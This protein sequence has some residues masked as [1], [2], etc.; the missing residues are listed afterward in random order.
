M[1]ITI[2]NGELEQKVGIALKG[3]NGRNSTKPIL[4]CIII[5]AKEDEILLEATN[6]EIGLRVKVD[7]TVE[8]EGCCAIDGKSLADISRKMPEGDV[9][10]QSDE[11]TA[12]I[13]GKKVK[14][15]LPVSDV[16]SF[17]G[18]PDL[19]EM[20]VSCS[21]LQGALKDALNGVLFSIAVTEVNQM[22]SVVHVKCEEGQMR[23]IGLD[24]HRIAIRA[25]EVQ[26]E[27]MELNLPGIPLKEI[28]KLLNSEE[29]KVD[30]CVTEHLA[31]FLMPDVWASMR[32]VEEKYFDISAFLQDKTNRNI[33]IDKTKLKDSVSRAL[34]LLADKV[35]KPKKPWELF[36]LTKDAFHRLRQI[37]GGKE[38][39]LWFQ[40]MEQ[41]HL[42]LPNAV[43]CGMAKE[44]I[45]PANI[46]GVPLSPTVIYNYL[47]RQ[48]TG[49]KGRRHMR[50]LLGTWEDYLSMAAYLKMPMDQDMVLRPRDLLLAH[51]EVLSQCG[52]REKGLRVVEI[53]N[54]FP[55]VEAV[56]ASIKEKYEYVGKTFSIVV[57]E[58]IEQIIEEGQALK[59]CLDRSDRY[60]ERIAN[61]ESY[62]V[63]LRR[64]Q[65]MEQPYYTMEIEPDG[66]T[67]Q[68]RTV[69]DNQNNDYH[70]AEKFLK[71]WQAAIRPRLS[72]EDFERQEISRQLRMY[73]LESLRN[74]KV[75]VHGGIHAGELLADILEA[76]LMEA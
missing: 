39:I 27:E 40:Y 62:I 58:K 17:P 70:R 52:G 47:K 57:P 34:L 11:K 5:K 1:K 18:L 32:L 3:V 54:K 24:G 61:Q 14:I 64:T 44:G 63:F 28:A 2:Q 23:L 75:T 69:G 15:K 13:S 76:D 25:L 45:E 42:T 50:E 7:G 66:T 51:R 22:L 49:C 74:D 35:Q 30:L 72:Q 4:K 16:E 67:R 12:V 56:L 37:N 46:S 38:E 10:I 6:L 29:Q 43:I 8:E 9:V 48:A 31:C 73:E 19:T 33:R 59:H 65:A 71:K 26:T 68:K 41:Q 21:V 36:G 60:F 55:R 53:A 20:E